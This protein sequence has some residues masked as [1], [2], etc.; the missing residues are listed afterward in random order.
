MARRE[1][2]GRVESNGTGSACLG[3]ERTMWAAA[4]KLRGSMDAAE[5][6]HVVLGLVFLKYISDAF[7]E[8]H[9]PLVS[10][11]PDEAEDKDSCSAEGVFWVPKEPHY[12]EDRHVTPL[13]GLA[14]EVWGQRIQIAVRIR[15]TVLFM[16]N[17]SNN[18]L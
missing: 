9:A 11:Y 17:E 14:V 18:E 10:N 12:W 6:K 16:L 3:F 7:Q 8:H 1:G 2:E 4:D 15:T 13:A 5:Y